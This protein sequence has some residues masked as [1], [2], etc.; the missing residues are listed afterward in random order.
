M[1]YFFRQIKMIP[2]MLL[3]FLL[4]LCVSGNPGS[5]IRETFVL[6][7]SQYPAQIKKSNPAHVYIIYTRLT[8]ENLRTEKFF[9]KDTIINLKG[10]LASSL[11]AS[12]ISYRLIFESRQEIDSVWQTDSRFR[13]TDKVFP[14]GKEAMQVYAY[15][16]SFSILDQ[17]VYN[18]GQ[19]YREET[20]RIPTL[21][22]LMRIEVVYTRADRNKYAAG[23]AWVL[24]IGIDEYEGGAIKKFKACESDAVEYNQF[25]SA[26]YHRMGLPLSDYH[27]YLLLGKSA[28]K[29]AILSA[30]KDIAAKAAPGDYFIF[31][32]SGYSQVMT[33][34]ST[35]F[36]TYFFPYDKKGIT[37]GSLGKFDITK[38][39]ISR[40]IS[41]KMLQ[42]HIQLIQARNQLFISEAGS[43]EN[44]KSEFIRTMMQNS[45]AIAAMLSINRVIM[46][47]NGFGREVS[48]PGENKT[49]GIINHCITRLDSIYN[50]YE[51]F[52]TGY[53]PSSIAL[54]LKA[55]ALYWQYSRSEYFDVFF[56]KNFLQQYREIFGDAEKTRGGIGKNKEVQKNAGLKGSRHALI[57]GTDNYKAKG[58]DKLNN[59]VFDAS[60]IA[61]ILKEDYKYEVQLLKDPP[62]DSIYEAM[63]KYYKEMK[64]DDQLII[65]VAGHGDYDKDLLD[66][67]FIVCA[68]SKSVEDDP[69]RNTYIQHTKL[70]KMI[71]KI[72][73]K[74][75]LVMLDICYGGFFD[76]EV[77]DNP[78]SSITN[79]NVLELLHNNAQYK[80]RKMLSSVGTEPAFDGKAGK[81]SPFAS[82]LISVLNAKGGNEGIIT[83]S[84]IYALLQ[85]ASLNETATLKISP[86]VAGFGDN[87]P[88]GEFIL[89]PI[90]N[91]N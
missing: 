88:L 9:R 57:I 78:A 45:P 84:D 80:V 79:R 81:H 74:Q 55:K 63:R 14:Y 18:Y 20:G 68:D 90:G 42:E 37:S 17:F 62:M 70:K 56:E 44:F 1:Q 83:L 87:N 35:N 28:T 24:S 23:A 3:I 31:S 41:L 89:I 66:D 51:I 52:G 15:D 86:H 27:V 34:D 65:Y 85:K 38:E 77:R 11:T 13:I 48:I 6:E 33:F 76:E 19:K 91:N 39:D 50:I 4:P 8:A 2:A 82:Y 72:P 73:A 12:G 60:E 49:A 54:S 29:E 69:L 53:K 58:W 25:F 16:S 22:Q 21:K 64:P 40:L 5:G 7:K 10:L 30:L 43:S 32:F 71:N 67:G 61:D 75:I 26:Q 47:P 46:V 59:P 36:N